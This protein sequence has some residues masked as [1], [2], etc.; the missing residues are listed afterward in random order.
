MGLTLNL[1]T[2][3]PMKT[4][5]GS[6][7]FWFL[8]LKACLIFLA[9][10]FLS[11]QAAFAA[12][13]PSIITQP[14]G[15]SVLAG[16]GATFTVVAGGQTPL[17]YQ[18]S[19]NATNLTNSIHIAGANSATLTISNLVAGDAG[20]YQVVVSNSHGTATSSN[21]MLTVLFRAAITGPPASQSVL[22]TSKRR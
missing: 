19:L 14:Q 15:Q 13:T 6:L 20:N 12:A 7:A 11:T 17:S 18:W 22:S 8:A 16:L 9:A 2:N 4:R 5:E 3:E 1:I 10:N 21:A